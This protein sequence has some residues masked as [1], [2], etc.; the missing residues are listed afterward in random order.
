MILIV[1]FLGDSLLR[2][3]SRFHGF[4][5]LFSHLDKHLSQILT[6][7]VKCFENA[8]KQSVVCTQSFFKCP[9]LID[10]HVSAGLPSVPRLR[11]WPELQ[12]FWKIDSRGDDCLWVMSTCEQLLWSVS[13]G[14]ECP[15]ISSLS[16]A[17]H[18][19]PLIT[20]SSIGSVV[21]EVWESNIWY[22]FQYKSFAKLFE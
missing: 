12:I 6:K 19:F 10:V 17:F 14:V 2:R 11:L 8:W 18:C 13:R 4:R 9:D 16:N 21:E 15:T 3:F 5:R 20:C 7:S 22:E 1:S